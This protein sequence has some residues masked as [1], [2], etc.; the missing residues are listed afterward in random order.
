MM[1]Q[2][3]PPCRHFGRAFLCALV[4][5]AGG[6][7]TQEVPV[8]DTQE[9]FNAA[10][11]VLSE[12]TYIN[13]LF[14]ECARLGDEV[15]LEA[16]SLQQDWLLKNWPLVSAA[17]DYFTDQEQSFGVLYEGKLLSL[18]AVKLAYDAEQRALKELNF[19]QRTTINQQKFC[20]NRLNALAKND[21]DISQKLNGKTFSFARENH[22]TGSALSKGRVPSMAGNLS[23]SREPGRTY[24]SLS[25]QFKQECPQVTLLV[26]HN[27]WPK[28]AYA[29]YCDETPI[30]LMTCEWGKCESRTN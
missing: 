19:N 20:E 6:C 11:Q 30:T 2:K 3:L 27:D 29:A 13:T 10:R 26:L 17:D 9:K 4:L 24:Y 7:A 16:L 21:M 1:S 25:E 22:L 18:N 5:L 14:G 23:P 8:N 12:A 15:E 28:E